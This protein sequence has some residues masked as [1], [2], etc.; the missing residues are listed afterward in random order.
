VLSMAAAMSLAMVAAL[1]AGALAAY[2]TLVSGLPGSV[3]LKSYQPKT[4]SL[5]Y[6]DDGSVL[7]SF[8]NERRF[9]VTLD[10]VPKHVQDAFIAAEDARFFSHTGIDPVGM[11]RALLKDLET[12]NFAQ[13][14]STMTQQ[15]ARIILLTR[16]KT[17]SRKLREIILAL[18]IE[19]SNS[20]VQILETYLNEIYLGRG[21]Y[22]IEAAAQSYYG[23]KTGD[24]T[25]SE[26]AYLAGVASSPSKYAPEHP[27]KAE[28]RKQ[29]VL[30]AMLKLNS[31]SKDEYKRASQER[32]AFLASSPDRGTK[33]SYFTEAARRYVISKYGEKALQEDGLRVW[34]TVDTDL[35]E[36]AEEAILQGVTAWEQ[37]HGRPAGLVKRLE[38]EEVQNMKSGPVESKLKPGASVQAVVVSGRESRKKTKD[39]ASL[40]DLTVMMKGGATYQV[41]AESGVPYRKNDLLKFKVK[42]M[43]DGK[44]ALEHDDLPPVQGALVSIENN[45]GY[46]KA[47]VGGADGETAGF[48]R[49]LQALRQPG[50]AFKP[51]I[52]AAALEWG[53][54]DPRTVIVDEPIAVKAGQGDREWIPDNP[55][56]RFQGPLTTRD[57]LVKSRNIPAVKVMMDLGPEAITQ[58]ARNLGIKSPIGGNLSSALGASEVTP[59]EL[60]SAYSVFPNMGVR[61]TPVLI[62]KIT[63]RNG[64]VL[65]DNTVK[66]L[67]V[68]KRAKKDI[69]EGVCVAVPK[70]LEVER[71]EVEGPGDTPESK[72]GCRVFEADRSN[73]VRAMSPQAAYLMLSMLREVTVSGTAS[74]VRRMGRPDV[75][76][77]TGTTNDYTDAWFIGFSPKYTTG[78]WI[79]YDAR[80]SLGTKEFGAKAALPVWMEYMSYALRADKPRVWPPP[81]G[82]ELVGASSPYFPPDRQFKQICPVDVIP[83]PVS[84]GLAG[85]SMGWAPV[86]YGALSQYGLVRVLSPRGK[87][88]GLASYAQD[89]KGNLVLQK[90]PALSFSP[91]GFGFRQ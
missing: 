86:P 70:S 6:A 37:R 18:R 21:S 50:S 45:T 58:M 39:S 31:I 79:G 15:V 16:E 12:G 49:A 13:G 77:K 73:M 47:L 85:Y 76:G 32:L 80:D 46:V 7:G 48:N 36:K 71:R 41:N 14:G 30:N 89:E 52:Y 44:P 84:A 5:F 33:K 51:V 83:I 1:V 38:P 61:V 26:A 56:G 9:P 23:K 82:I 69:E 27:E 74:S 87:T 8:Y 75:G 81:P 35:Q 62:K 19:R 29:Y 17:I 42:E 53:K 4:V 66:P 54:Y 63:D 43:A 88:I 90:I 22:G 11:L 67:D 60:T 72:T 68:V 55:D 3:D 40:Y 64:K 20:K 10:T 2:F 28:P 59:M 25:I 78:G 65:E 24:L 34:T 57:A 91:E